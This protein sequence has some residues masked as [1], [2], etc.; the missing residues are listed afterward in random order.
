MDHMATTMERQV[1]ERVVR[2]N[3][4]AVEALLLWPRSVGVSAA[5]AQESGLWP[6]FAV[7]LDERDPDEDPGVM[8]L[9]DLLDRPEHLE[10]ISVVEGRCQWTIIDPRHALLELSVHATAPVQFDVDIILPARSVL[11]TLA[12]LA[13]GGTVAI[14][15]TR[16]ARKLSERVDIRDA[17]NKLVLF[18]CPPSKDLAALANVVSAA[19]R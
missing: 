11:G 2:P 16:H 5:T 13:K 18:S 7:V 10:R 3:L 6:V 15:N 12:L 1:T 8:P 4:I 17:L 9:F 14:T 19:V